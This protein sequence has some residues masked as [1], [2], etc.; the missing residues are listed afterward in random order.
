MKKIEKKMA[1]RQVQDLDAQAK[2]HAK[3]NTVQFGEKKSPDFGDHNVFSYV[4]SQKVHKSHALRERNEKL[5]SMMDGQ[6][7]S[8][9]RDAMKEME[10][11]ERDRRTMDEKDEKML[12]DRAKIRKQ[13]EI[14]TKYY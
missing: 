1:L 12:A 5:I 6:F 4:Y 10:V 13:K 3:A 2:L 7:S 8:P 9:K 11:M 14:E